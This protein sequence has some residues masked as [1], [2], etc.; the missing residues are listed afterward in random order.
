MNK[1]TKVVILAG[2][3][4]TRLGELTQTIP[5]PMVEI[6]N[7]PII[8]HIMRTYSNYGFSRFE[9]CCGYKGHIIKEYFHNYKVNTTDF[10]VYTK[11]NY[12]SYCDSSDTDWTV[13]LTDTGE[14]TMTGG[15]LLRIKQKISDTFMMT[16]G[17]GL[18]DINIAELLEF[19]KSHGKIATVTAVNP[20][21][22]FGVLEIEKDKS[23]SAFIEKP[24]DNHWING[25]FFVLEPGVFDYIDKG[26]STIFEHNPLRRLAEDGQLKAFKH[27]G[28]WKPMDTMKDKG[29]LQLLWES[30]EAPWKVW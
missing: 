6:G 24:N 9:I 8:W 14:D 13:S 17:D 11:Y 20:P 5:K 25:G 29:E 10:T 23:V 21:G 3:G 26:D 15:R 16:Y 28:F 12:T 18:S 19:H 7:R 22:R 1:S 30:G 2:G 27:E 4:G